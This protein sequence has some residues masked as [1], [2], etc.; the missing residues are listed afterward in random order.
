MVLEGGLRAESFSAYM[1]GERTLLDP[2]YSG[3][4]DS[5]AVDKTVR[6]GIIG[7]NR[8]TTVSYVH[9]I[10]KIDIELYSCITDDITT[11]E[12]VI[13]NERIQHINDRHPGDYE[14]IKW[15]IQEILDSPDYIL[16]DTNKE[17]TGLI[18]KN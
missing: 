12:V 6:S 2:E 10:G 11:D 7:K 1:R 17:N 9:K 3:F 4:I 8:E 5:K 15:H 16:E 14:Y 13:T 18:L